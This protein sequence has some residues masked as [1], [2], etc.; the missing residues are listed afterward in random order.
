MPA[1]L[2]AKKEIE[3]QFESEKWQKISTALE[4]KCGEKYSSSVVMKKFKE[5]SKK[6][7][8]SPIVI[9]DED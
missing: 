5:L 4:A 1:L 8:G 3:S 9:K 6:S 7:A 2:E